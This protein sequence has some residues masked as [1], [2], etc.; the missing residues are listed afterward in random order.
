MEWFALFSALGFGI[1]DYM[2]GKLS[3]DN[4]S[5]R[6]TAISQSCAL[7]IYIVLALLVPGTPTVQGFIAGGA[8]G[9]CNALGLYLF[10]SAMAQGTVG[11]VISITALLGAALPAC[12][13]FLRGDNLSG[14]L[15]G[16]LVFGALAV[17]AFAI[18]RRED[19]KNSRAMTPL[20]WVKTVV[21]GTLLSG[22]FMSLT[23]APAG[24]GAWPLVAV[25]TCSTGLALTLSLI[26]TKGV[27]LPKKIVKPLIVMVCAIGLAY[28][29][30]VFATQASVLAIASVLTALYPIPTIILARVIDHEHLTRLQ[31]VGALCALVAVVFIALG[32]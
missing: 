31:L 1:S 13:G 11:V 16:G 21:G 19:L 32:R 17:V 20:L 10:Y 7:A 14:M 6:V 27:S 4:A 30:Q 8:A 26:T 3:R 2:G 24:G 9:I 18:P 12:F 15:V 28:F 22:S 5:I 25:G 23:F 29:G